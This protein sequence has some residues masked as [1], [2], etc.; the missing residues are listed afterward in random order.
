MRSAAIRPLEA[1]SA[2][3]DLESCRQAFLG[4]V[5]RILK[6]LFPTNVFSWVGAK[7]NQE[8]TVDESD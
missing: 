2:G 8:S 4:I 3:F 1:Q 7:D 6:V 5:S